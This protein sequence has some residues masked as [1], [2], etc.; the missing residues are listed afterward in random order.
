[1]TQHEWI[2][3]LAIIDKIQI[4]NNPYYTK[5]QKELWKLFV[6]EMKK[7]AHA[8]IPPQNFQ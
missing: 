5:E 7:Q 8:S 1:M 2:E 3:I 4:E 6:D